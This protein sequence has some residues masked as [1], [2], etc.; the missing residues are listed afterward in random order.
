MQITLSKKILPLLIF[1][2]H[3]IWFV[4]K[5]GF[6]SIC[7]NISLVLT[8]QI[9]LCVLTLRILLKKNNIVVKQNEQSS[10]SSEK[11]SQISSESMK[12]EVVAEKLDGSP[13]SNKRKSSK[14][15][16]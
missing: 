7:G 13:V 1:V 12:E 10:S 11:Y 15:K 14:V 3:S 8:F 5:H 6:K 16:I 2:V 9:L 4:Y